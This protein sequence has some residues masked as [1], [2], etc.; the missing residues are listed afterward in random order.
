[1]GYQVVQQPD[2]KLA[3]FSS[4]TDTII[5]YD[6]TRQEISDW[7]VERATADARRDVEQVLDHVEAGEPHRAYFQFAHT[8]DEV[9]QVDREHGGEAHKEFAARSGRP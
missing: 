9:L 8:W 7:F 6:A 2:G 1:V 3:V 5:I 4:Y